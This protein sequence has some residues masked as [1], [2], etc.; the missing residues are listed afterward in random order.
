MAV[1]KRWAL[2]AFLPFVMFAAFFP[3]A[4]GGQ[5]AKVDGEAIPVKSLV[6]SEFKRG[7]GN[8]FGKLEYLGGLVMATKNGE[9]GAVSSI[10]I[11]PDHASISSRSW[12]PA[13]GR[14]ARSSATPM[15]SC[16]ASSDYKIYID[17][18][19][20]TAARARIT[21]TIWTPRAW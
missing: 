8:R 13:I 14:S 11:L 3:V 18:R 16:P 20:R 5:P 21:R 10:R 4:F 17:A 6:I 9:M 12:T 2:V 1:K 7:A 15:A 19:A